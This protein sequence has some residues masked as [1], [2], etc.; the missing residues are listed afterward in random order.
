MGSAE[1]DGA[2]LGEFRV[3]V[4]ASTRLEE[5]GSLGEDPKMSRS[6]SSDGVR[7]RGERGGREIASSSGTG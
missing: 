1:E 3:R 6:L 4:R 2:G 5:D 7:G